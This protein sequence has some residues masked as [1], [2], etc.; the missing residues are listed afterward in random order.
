MLS[1]ALGP[2]RA[3]AVRRG[4]PRALAPLPRVMCRLQRSP[5]AVSRLSPPPRAVGHLEPLV[6][7]CEMPTTFAAHLP[8]VSGYPVTDE[9]WV[10]VSK[11]GQQRQSSAG[12]AQEG[13][14]RCYPWAGTVVKLP[15]GNVCPCAVTGGAPTSNRRDG[16]NKRDPLMDQ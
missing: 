5:R 6:A 13:F 7:R 3:L 11:P 16:C 1:A 15:V 9:C 12:G 8:G 14:S 2:S 10:L 4:L